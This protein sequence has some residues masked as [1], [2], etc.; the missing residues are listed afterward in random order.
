MGF[1][2]RVIG[3]TDRNSGNWLVKDGHVVGVDHS[4]A[5][6]EIDVDDFEDLAWG[7]HETL[8]SEQMELTLGQR[9]ILENILDDW[10]GLV[11]SMPEKMDPRRLTS[12]RER[13]ELILERG[14][15]E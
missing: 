7:W 11:F 4:L 2:D 9:A 13:I 1:F 12:M 10:E 6:R 14:S 5:F 8:T 3:N 15:W